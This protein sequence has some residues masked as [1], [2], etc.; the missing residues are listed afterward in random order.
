MSNSKTQHGPMSVQRAIIAPPGDMR[1][2]RVRYRP[3]CHIIIHTRLATYNT[4]TR[5]AVMANCSP[6]PPGTPLIF[7]VTTLVEASFTVG[8]QRHGGWVTK[9]SLLRLWSTSRPRPR[10]PSSCYQQCYYITISRVVPSASI[11]EKNRRCDALLQHARSVG[12]I[13][14]HYDEKWPLY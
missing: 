8:I 13:C 12:D 2:Y 10:P 5:G 1:G 14:H 11:M 4:M 3:P 7:G 6:N 9:R